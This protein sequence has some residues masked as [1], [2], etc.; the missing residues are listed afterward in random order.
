MS[1]QGAGVTEHCRD[2]SARYSDGDGGFLLRPTWRPTS[3]R[4]PNTRRNGSGNCP[5]RRTI[6]GPAGVDAIR[7]AGLHRLTLPVADGGQGAGMHDAVE[8]LAAIAAIDASLALGLAM[9]TQVLGAAVETRGWPEAPFRRL[10]AAVRD[11]GA[12]VNAASTEEGSGSP[13]RGGLPATRAVKHDGA[14]FHLSG[15]KTFT[16]WLPVLRFAV[17][18]ALMA[19]EARHG[20]R[21]RRG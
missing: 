19:D 16:T 6:S 10:V 7:E 2:G 21:T 15:E 3:R 12:L 18:T 20:R 11:E 4:E 5:V 13:A 1:K 14:T 17:V 8:V 9:Q